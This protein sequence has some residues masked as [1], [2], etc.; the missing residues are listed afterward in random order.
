MTPPAYQHQ[1]NSSGHFAAC[2]TTAHAPPY[3]TPVQNLRVTAPWLLPSTQLPLCY[4]ADEIQIETQVVA[5]NM[6]FHLPTHQHL[7][8]FRKTNKKTD[9][10]VYNQKTWTFGIGNTTEIFHFPG[11]SELTKIRY[12]FFLIFFFLNLY[13]INLINHINYHVSTE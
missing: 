7:K 2:T 10:S 5:T 9:W 1:S 13:H 4:D 11:N 8:N 6:S 12:P 3:Q